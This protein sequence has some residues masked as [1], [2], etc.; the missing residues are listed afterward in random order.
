MNLSNIHTDAQGNVVLPLIL[1]KEEFVNLKAALLDLGML[2]IIADDAATIAQRNSVYFMGSL[3]RDVYDWEAD[4]AV[5][6][7]QKRHRNMH[8]RP[9]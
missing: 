3:F 8:V 9:Q 5:K 4:K 2:A 6:K 1:S 7:A